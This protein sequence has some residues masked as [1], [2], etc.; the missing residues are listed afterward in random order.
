MMTPGLQ[1]VSLML[2]TRIGWAGRHWAL[3]F[4]T[5]LVVSARYDRRKG[6]RHKTF[7]DYAQQML[8]CLRRWLPDRD[9]VVVADGG[10]AARVP[11]ALP[12]YVKADCRRHQTAQG[13]VPVPARATAAARPDRA[14]PGGRSA[15]AQS[16]GGA[17]RSRYTMDSLPRHRFRRQ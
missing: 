6:R 1:W 15:I 13:R 8:V 17:G 5:A 4:L 11:A 9:L 3:P 16:H 10:Y 2:L 7:T 14:A 12:E